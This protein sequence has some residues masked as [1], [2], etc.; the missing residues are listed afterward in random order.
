MCIHA[1]ILPQ[2]PQGVRRESSFIKTWDFTKY[3]EILIRNMTN[4]CW[5]WLY[6]KILKRHK[7]VISRRNLSLYYKYNI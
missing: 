4:I 1:H 5:S 3:R 6:K 2:T 7:V